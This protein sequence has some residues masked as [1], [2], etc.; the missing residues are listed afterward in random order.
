MRTGLLRFIMTVAIVVTSISCA[1]ETC[2]QPE[3][4]ISGTLQH[5]QI[6]EIAGTYSDGEVDQDGNIIQMPAH[7]TFCEHLVTLG[8]EYG[9]E[10][11]YS[12]IPFELSAHSVRIDGNFDETGENMIYTLEYTCEAINP[13]Q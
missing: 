8:R 9:H 2:W 4:S 3:L 10:V 7:E 5:D 13:C 6:V 11:D 1:D 12:G